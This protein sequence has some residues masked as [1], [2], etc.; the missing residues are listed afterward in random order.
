MSLEFVQ[1][2]RDQ[3]FFFQLWDFIF[4]VVYI[5]VKLF[6]RVVKFHSIVSSVLFHSV[7]RCFLVSLE[8]LKKKKKRL[9]FYV[10]VE[11]DIGRFGCIALI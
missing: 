4:W 5:V 8:L 3:L 9:D 7:V 11:L 10:V 1:K 2:K 6:Y